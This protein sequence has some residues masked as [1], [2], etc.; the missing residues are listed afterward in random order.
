M[1]PI[2]LIKTNKFPNE[3]EGNGFEKFYT[4]FYTVKYCGQ[5]RHRYLT[6]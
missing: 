4:N 5:T 6:Y 2:Y 1:V 3:V